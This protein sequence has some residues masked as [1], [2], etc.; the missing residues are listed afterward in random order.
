MIGLKIFNENRHACEPLPQYME[1][2]SNWARLSLGGFWISA[3]VS[4]GG[5]DGQ[6]M[7]SG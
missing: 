7:G 6:R 5:R 2:A 1:V 4:A 3:G